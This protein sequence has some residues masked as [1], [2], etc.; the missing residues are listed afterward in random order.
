[1]DVQ[2]SSLDLHHQGVAGGGGGGGQQMTRCAHAKIAKMLTYE[3]YYSGMMLGWLDLRNARTWCRTWPPDRRNI[4]IARDVNL[5]LSDV[6]LHP[7]A[8]RPSQRWVVAGVAVL[9]GVSAKWFH[10]E[11]ILN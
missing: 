9:H 10:Q 3:M 4:P 1:M 7:R 11:N 8:V 2:S 5:R 6:R